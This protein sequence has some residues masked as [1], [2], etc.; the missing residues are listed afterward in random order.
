[1]RQAQPL[2]LQI[3]AFGWV[4]QLE[5]RRNRR[6]SEGFI[7][8]PSMAQATTAAMLRA[9]WHAHGTDDPTSPVAVNISSERVR[10]ASW[11]LDGVRQGQPLGDLLGYRFE[12]SLHDRHAD[13]QIRPV[14]E[15]LLTIQGKPNASL[16]QPVDGIDL[17]ESYRSGQLSGLTQPVKRAILD[18]E[19]T[20]DAVQDVGLFEAV[21]QLASG[22]YDRATAM[23]DSISTGIISPPELRA[24][25][26]PHSAVSVE[27][28]V[29]ILLSPERVETN[30]GWVE[31]IRDGIA[32]ALEG[33]VASLVPPAGDISFLAAEINPDGLPGAITPLTMAQLGL[34]ALDAIYLVGDDPASV[35]AAIKTLTAG[36]VGAVGTVTIDPASGDGPVSLADFIV[37]AAELR[38]L[39]ELLRSL[40]AR[41]LHQ[42]SGWDDAEGDPSTALNGVEAFILGVDRLSD[43]LDNAIDDGQLENMAAIVSQY[44]RM[45]ISNGA[46]PR[47]VAGAIKLQ[48][49]ETRRRNY[50]VAQ[51]VDPNNR[52]P[53]LE[54]RLAAFLGQRIPVLGLFSLTSTADGA[55]VDV[56]QG[57]AA[58]LEVDDWFDA[59]SRVRPE[60][61]KLAAVGLISELM[62]AA[63]LALRAG[64]DPL[65]PGEGWAATRRPAGAG[66]LSIVAACGPDGPPAEGQTAC[67]LFVDQWSEPIPSNQR[68]TGLTFQ[69]DA[70]RTARPRPGCWRSPQMVNRGT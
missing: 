59:V 16:D 32:P 53:G 39:V 67:G 35:P 70:P 1:M 28:R 34:S 3:G 9:G 61:G 27:H 33:W 13:D 62:G 42:A 26:T 14:R 44:A 63:G 56:T 49:L 48:D 55:V 66:R 23:M 69:Y 50:M 19:A 58:L 25:L 52:Q 60:I 64:Q 18:L 65:D 21:H 29:V 47:D 37:L 12:R 30:R 2:G 31:G 41:D 22:S 57:P 45:G 20:F 46:S 68:T 15:M 6:P 4:T 17:L 54:A 5:P 10:T 36:T 24:P 40:D 7:H 38:R 11:L 8:T 51:K 43:D